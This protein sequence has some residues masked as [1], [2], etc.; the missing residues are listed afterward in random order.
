MMCS[1]IVGAE[2]SEPPVAQLEAFQD[3]PMSSPLL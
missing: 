2:V 1:E 3:S